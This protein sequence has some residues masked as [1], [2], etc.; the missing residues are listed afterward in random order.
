MIPSLKPLIFGAI[1]LS[2]G[3][4]VSAESINTAQQI[5]THPASVKEIMQRVADYQEKD[6]GGVIQTDWKVGTYYSGLYAAYQATGDEAFR[7]KALAWCEAANWT[8]SENHFFADDI[9]AAQTFLDVYLDEKDPSMIADTAAAL[10]PYFGK[11]TIDR[12]QLGHAVWKGD[13]RPFTGRNVWWWCDSLYMAPPVLTRMYSATGDQRYLD[14]LHTLYW[15]TVDFL[16]SEDD[17][18]FYRDESFFG[19]ETPSGKPVYWSR[20]NGWVYGGLIRTLDHLPADDPHRQDYIDLFVKMT[21]SLVDLQQADGMWRPALNDPDWKPSKESSGTAFFTFGLLAG[22]NR[23]YLEKEAY[24]PVALK[25]WE[26]LVGCINTDGRLGYA[27]LVGKAPHHVR[28]TDS[29]DYTHGAFLLAASELYKMDLKNSDFAEL[30]DPY[31]VKLLARDGAWTWFN[32]ERVLYDGAGLYIGSI[33]SKGTSRID[34]YSTIHVQSPFAYQPYPLSSWQSKDDHNNP[35]LLQLASGDLLAAYSK[36]NLEDVWYTRRGNKKGPDDWRT[37]EWSDEQPIEAVAK[38]T[39]NNLFQ[40]TAENGRVFNFM[41]LVG[42]NPTLFI[43][44]DEG[45]TWSEPI[46]LIRSGNERTRPYVK[47]SSNGVDRIDLIFTDAHPRKDNENNVYHIYYQNEAFHKSDGTL[48]RTLE[49]VKSQPLLPSDGTRI[50][51]GT[52]AG[53]GWVWDLE[54]DKNGQPV[55]AF[56]NSVDNEIGNDLRY[57]LAHWDNVSK[58]WTQRQI[59]FAGTHL[60]DREEHYAGG[61]AI[62]PQ[63]TDVIYLSADVDPATGAPNSTG[64]YQ[65]FRGTLEHGSWS[66]EQLTHDAQV[67]NI[68]PIVPR[69]HDFDKIALWVQGRYTTYT[70]YDTAIVGIL[71]KSE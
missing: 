33:D 65:M 26:G 58:K 59:A 9:C 27:Q 35:A 39:Y 30:E 5:L 24:L 60:Y 4:S 40:L 46:E 6:F 29:I 47:Y 10:E 55:V 20:G 34:Y 28:P 64:R 68:R 8:L 17:G 42:W 67:D 37:V 21:R 61:I 15:D 36:H 14:L 56:I 50:Y 70:D 53:R 54:Y 44:G 18:L 1:A 52:E 31:E 11:E 49:E 7:E 66:F 43:S 48:I 71:E 3:I 23:G 62:D 13:P 25:A 12:K 45:Q 41:R 63:N 32:D 69:G 22:I 51:A 2:A 19:M 57:R 16:F 38:T